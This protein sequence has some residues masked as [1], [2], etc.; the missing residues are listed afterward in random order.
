VRTTGG[1][2]WNASAPDPSTLDT[3]AE[4]ELRAVYEEWVRPLRI[5]HVSAFSDDSSL[6]ERIAETLAEGEGSQELYLNTELARSLSVNG[7]LWSTPI[8]VLG[9]RDATEDAHWAALVFGSE[10]LNELSEPEQMT[11]ALKGH[12]VSPV[13][14]FL[15]IEP[16]VRPSTDGLEETAFGVGGVGLG[17]IGV[18]GGG[19]DY[20]IGHGPRLDREGYLRDRLRRELTRCGGSP[21]SAYAEVET[22]LDEIVRVE[23]GG[24]RGVLFSAVAD[25]LSEGAWALL[26][27]S[28][29][30]EEDAQFRVEL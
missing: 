21:G 1:L 5:D 27:P 2:V 7:E 22:T 6:G 13:T 9:R 24:T 16:G 19:R 14:S 23:V 20:V 29:F 8:K 17:G 28:G 25:C 12:A 30:D 18:S 4:A 3:E 26:L 10:L 11:L 15:A